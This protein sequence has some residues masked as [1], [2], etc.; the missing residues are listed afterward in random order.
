MKIVHFITGLNTGGAENMLFKFINNYG[1]NNEQLVIALID[2]ESPIKNKIEELNIKVFSL[3][4]SKR[5]PFRLNLFKCYFLIKNFNPDIFQGWMY[6]A[7][8]IMTLFHFFF[9]KVKI[10]WGIRQTLYDITKEKINT[11]II[12]YLS[13]LIMYRVK[14][15]FFNSSISMSQ[16]TKYGFD[17]EKSVFIPNG[18]EINFY[19]AASISN[20]RKKIRNSFKL[21]DN[22]IL[23][24]LV[25]RF[26]PMKGHSVFIKS[27][28]KIIEMNLE[29][30]VKFVCIGSNIKTAGLEKS[31]PIQY[32]KYFIF[33]DE[34]ANINEIYAAIDIAINCSIRGEGFSNVIGEAMLMGLPCIATDVG[35]TKKL[36]VNNSYLAIPGSSSSLAEYMVEMILLTDNKR[37]WIGSEN[38]KIIQ[39]N[40]D[41]KKILNLYKSEYEK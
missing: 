21:K 12:I 26:H 4:I 3:G 18:F 27:C 8:F 15:I 34:T 11:R 40:Y 28:I 38:R 29:K 16:H 2:S 22:E 10:F 14:K 9:P 7:N 32:S 13:K 35:E 23:I 6:H 33:L 39:K 24:G 17:K 19:D 31:I 5:N 41:I 20:I 25:A 30:K 36:L 37:A 1:D